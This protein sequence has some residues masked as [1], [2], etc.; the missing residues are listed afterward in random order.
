MTQKNIIIIGGFG[1]IGKQ[2]ASDLIRIGHKIII[3]DLKSESN[4]EWL[5]SFPK[6]TI[7]FSEMNIKNGDSIDETI[8]AC[9]KEFGVVDACINLAYP[10]S[11]TWG[12]S[13]ED[14]SFEQ[15]SNHLNLQLGTC[16]LLSQRFIKYFIKQGSGNLVLCSSIQGVSAP[17]FEHYEGTY[18]TSPI[19]YTSAKT[20][21]IGITRWLAKYCKNKNIRVNCI[22]PG[23]IF[24]NQNDSFLE[25]Y[26]SSC[27][28]KGMLDPKDLSGTIKFLISEDS[29]FINGQN[30]IIDDGWTL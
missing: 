24:Q 12:K 4:T 14:I 11:S 23:G 18:M 20:G 25:K 8:M 17:K 1:L 27:L 3:G 22:S 6:G 26:N 7:L 5:S 10:K 9:E 21:I 15:I 13:F 19:E 28:S 29:E 30:I 2:V 16:I